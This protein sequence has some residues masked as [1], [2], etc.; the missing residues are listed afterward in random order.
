MAIIFPSIRRSSFQTL[1][2]LS[3]AKAFH[4]LFMGKA[5]GKV[6][7]KVPVMCRQALSLGR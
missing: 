5:V 4:L 6:A 1:D 2:G 7:D 3:M